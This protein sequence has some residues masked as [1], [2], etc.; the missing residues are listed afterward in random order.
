MSHHLKNWLEILL[1][2]DFEVIYKFAVDEKDAL[3]PLARKASWEVLDSIGFNEVKYYSNYQY[4][5][6]L[7]EKRLRDEVLVD[8][9][10]ENASIVGF[11]SAKGDKVAL[12]AKESQPTHIEQYR[13][14][15]ILR[16]VVDQQV[17]KWLK[18]G[19]IRIMNEHTQWNTP[20]VA[21]SPAATSVSDMI[22]MRLSRFASMLG[23]FYR[24]RARRL[25]P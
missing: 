2:F 17:V 7:F 8:L 4:Y 5:L 16:S 11:R 12:D 24:K 21:S 23:F 9:F 25:I 10:K 13:T 20:L 18:D 3:L 19:A 14:N 22:T 1:S 6:S 15:H